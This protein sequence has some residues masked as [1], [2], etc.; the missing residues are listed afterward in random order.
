MTQGGTIYP[1]MD[2]MVPATYRFQERLKVTH[3]E[4]KPLIADGIDYIIVPGHWTKDT[5]K[6]FGERLRADHGDH[7][8][9][10]ILK[11]DS[12]DV[13]EA[14]EQGL[15]PDPLDADISAPVEA[16]VDEPGAASDDEAGSDG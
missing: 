3:E 5:L 8:P 9:W 12:G 7:A 6:E 15:R 16:D 11:V 14:L 2:V 13:Y 1:E 10:V 4:L